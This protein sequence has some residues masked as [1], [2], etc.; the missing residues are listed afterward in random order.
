MILKNNAGRE[1]EVELSYGCEPDDPPECE[2]ASW[3][4]GDDELTDED[5]DELLEHN[6][7]RVQ[8][9]W[10]E[11]MVGWAESAFEGER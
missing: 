5:L 8:E 6:A 9:G 2:G 4:E 7:G 3:V 10:M 1:A 11:S